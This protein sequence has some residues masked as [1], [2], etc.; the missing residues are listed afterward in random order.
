MERLIMRNEVRNIVGKKNNRW[1]VK[2]FAGMRGHASLWLCE[3]DCGNT[4]IL[5]G[6]SLRPG[7]TGSCGCLRREVTRKR[8]L[9]NNP[10]IKTH[11]MTGTP[12]W[13][14]Y[15]DARHRCRNPKNKRYADY[16]G[17]GIEFHF[18]SFEEFLE[19]LGRRPE[20]TSLDR[21]NND[22]HY[23]KG[24]VRWATPHEQRVNQ[25]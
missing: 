16:G 13:S 10:V 21:I 25:R 15:K 18:E 7:G 1:T 2:S 8:N 14:A 11:G 19:E 4:K 23:E 9:T 3:C 5:V 6:S 20:G 12:E 17:R 22:G 24:N